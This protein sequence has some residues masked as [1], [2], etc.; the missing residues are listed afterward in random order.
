[1]HT[2]I[3]L[4]EKEKRRFEVIL[5]C[6]TRKLTNQQAA[7]ILD[8]SKRHIQRIKAVVRL[9]EVQGVIHGLKGK[10]SNHRKK[11]SI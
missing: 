10:P 3:P 2:Q 9:H 4:T 11:I 5:L 7:T 1:M 6:L 8:R